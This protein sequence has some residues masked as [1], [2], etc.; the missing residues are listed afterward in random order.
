M[1][2]RIPGA[3]T[4]AVAILCLGAPLALATDATTPTGEAGVDPNDPAAHDPIEGLN[5]AIFEVNGVFYE[6]TTPIVEATPDPIRGLFKAVGTAV[7]APVRIVTNMATD[8]PSNE[9][10]ADIARQNDVDCGF[11]V[12]LPLAGP[13][14]SRDAAGTGVELVAN[15]VGH[16]IV[17]GAGSAANDR[18]EAEVKI[19]QLDGAIDKYALARSA[20]LQERGCVVA[21]EDDSPSAFGT[22]KASTEK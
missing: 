17:L 18:I 5:R 16:V 10:L 8:D 21:P 2:R 3:L 13:T 9:H 6:I 1:I 11:F 14:T 12:V 20:T 22:E 4:G 19:R 15:P 7:T